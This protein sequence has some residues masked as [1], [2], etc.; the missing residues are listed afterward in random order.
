MWNNRVTLTVVAALGLLVAACALAG[1][2]YA[3]RYAERRGAILTA[4]AV[5]Q[6][7]QVNRATQNARAT[8]AAHFP[9][10]TAVAGATLTEAAQPT[11]TPTPTNTPT[12][13]P[14]A[15]ATLPPAVVA[16]PAT[17]TG[18]DRRLY[19]V[20]GG[21]QVRDATT[22]ERGAALSIVARLEDQ[23]WV[24]VETSDGLV[25]W[26]R[27]D[28]L[29]RGD[30]ACQANIYEISYLLG[31]VEGRR[32]A[33][34]D[35]LISNENVWVSSAGQ[36]VSPVVSGYGEAQLVLTTNG[37]DYLRPTSAALRDV[38]AFELVTTFARVN[39]VTGSYVGV[40]FRDNGVTYYEVR[41]QRNCQIGVYAVNEPVFTRSVD[42]GANTCTDEQD[43]WLHLT[44]TD[45]N[46]LTVQFNDAD[47]F[48]VTLEDAAG[49]YAGGGI[50]L[51]VARARA[52]FDFVVVT[53]PGE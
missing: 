17:L 8:L 32:V 11:I 49:L 2:F 27:S 22:L 36:A 25:G 53:T 50:A 26:M 7:A 24:Q 12:N 3:P 10:E 5:T 37:V 48:E 40:R 20:P 19:P 38:P 23:G 29:E 52:T 28:N 41:I 9:T 45:D 39:F 6:L 21:G 44:F 15:T 30:G 1:A 13:T 18:D 14:T 31:L 46:V 51:V 34:D 16:C 47:P 35:T 4:N 33:A 43:D 42:P